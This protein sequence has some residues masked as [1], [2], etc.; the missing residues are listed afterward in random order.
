MQYDQSID[1]RKLRYVLYARKSTEDD[2]RQVRSIGD[3][4]RDCQ[5]LAQDLDLRVVDIIKE[6]KSAK[7]PHQRPLFTKMLKDLR[8]KKYDAILCWH[9]DRLCRNMLEAGEIID[10]LDAYSARPAPSQSP[11]Q[12]RR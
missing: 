10:M 12:Q 2:T 8:A 7:R 11:V 9:P 5:K 3:Q 1:I 6:T 4:I